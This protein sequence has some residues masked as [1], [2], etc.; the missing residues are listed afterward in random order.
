[1]TMPRDPKHHQF[2][3]FQPANSAKR[4]MH[5]T[6]LRLVCEQYREQY[7][8]EQTYVVPQEEI[9]T[10]QFAQICG[11]HS[12]GTCA[13]AEERRSRRR[14]ATGRGPRGSLCCSQLVASALRR[15]ASPSLRPC[16]STYARVRIS[17]PMPNLLHPANTGY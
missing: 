7:T 8:T 14:R 15:R 16:A 11:F 5:A 3:I 12:V 10:K 6:C 4:H 17:A 9:L 13:C 1:M 2:P